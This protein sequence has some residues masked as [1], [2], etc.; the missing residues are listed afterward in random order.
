MIVPSHIRMTQKPKPL[1]L[2]VN[3]PAT[4]KSYPFK[5]ISKSTVSSLR[6]S[7]VSPVSGDTH[8]IPCLS[9]NYAGTVPKSPNL[10]TIACIKSNSP[11]SDIPVMAGKKCSRMEKWQSVQSML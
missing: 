5:A 10:T 9:M 6:S 2:K 4:K 7:L 11:F 8:C 3:G 1:P